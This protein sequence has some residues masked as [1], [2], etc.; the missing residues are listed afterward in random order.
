MNQRVVVDPIT[1][2]EG[3]L[4]IEAETDAEGRITRASSAGIFA[5]APRKMPR[6]RGP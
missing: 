3:H 4:R 5:S 2:I 6:L 1:R